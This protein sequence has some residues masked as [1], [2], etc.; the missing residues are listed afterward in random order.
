[1]LLLMFGILLQLIGGSLFGVGLFSSTEAARVAS[2][3][4]TRVQ[5]YRR[6]VHHWHL[7]QLFDAPFDAQTLVF[8][9][10]LSWVCVG[11]LY[12]LAWLA[13]AWHL[14]E[15][16]VAAN[17]LGVVMLLIVAWL[18]STCRSRDDLIFVF[19][20]PAFG[21]VPLVIAVPFVFS[22]FIHLSPLERLL[23]TALLVPSVYLAL[24]LSV[25]MSWVVSTY[26]KLVLMVVGTTIYTIGM[27]IL[28][29]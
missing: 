10:I 22:L 12:G 4:H 26:V 29:Q 15:A 21:F 13:A 1:M 14:A 11:V 28:A 20:H 8:H 2:A 6:L 3:A 18:S 9:A 27:V 7:P 17:I 23:G 16:G 5:K 25:V 24:F 19:A